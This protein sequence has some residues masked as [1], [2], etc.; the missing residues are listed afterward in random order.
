M[1]R[2]EETKIKKIVDLVL[3]LW[4]IDYLNIV[5]GYQDDRKFNWTTPTRTKA[6]LDECIRTDQNLKDAY[7]KDQDFLMRKITMNKITM[8]I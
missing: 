6:V 3:K 2:S 5:I 4:N 1:T 8:V 7:D